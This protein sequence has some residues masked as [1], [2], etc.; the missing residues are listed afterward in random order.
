[1]LMKLNLINFYIIKIVLQ[2]GV[3]YDLFLF[4]HDIAT[5]I[6]STLFHAHSG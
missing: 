5:S 2:I 6:M 1:M 3:K 4:S